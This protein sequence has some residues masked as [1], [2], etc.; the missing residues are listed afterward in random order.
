MQQPESTTACRS[1]D[2]G[3]TNS[4][5]HRSSSLSQ[6]QRLVSNFCH[7]S[8]NRV[9]AMCVDCAS[10]RTG[11]RCVASGNATTRFS[12]LWMQ[13]Y[14]ATASLDSYTEFNISRRATGPFQAQLCPRKKGMLARDL[15]AL[16][17]EEIRFAKT[18]PESR[19]VLL[20]STR[21]RERRLALLQRHRA[22]CSN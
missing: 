20:Q 11:P 6:P 2:R 7:A 4:V 19:I 18:S 12:K 13:I 16:P 14:A 9:A 10:S 1:R 5:K 22:I 3:I 15:S 21:S 8:C 17:F